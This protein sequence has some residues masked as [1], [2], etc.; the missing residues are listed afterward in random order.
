MSLKKFSLA[1]SFQDD[2]LIF[3]SDSLNI[4]ILE[5]SKHRIFQW[6]NVLIEEMFEI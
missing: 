3:T 6:S 2:R 5:I 1:K 4:K